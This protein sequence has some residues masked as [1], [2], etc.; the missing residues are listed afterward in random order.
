MKK[1]YKYQQTVD[2]NGLNYL[3]SQAE[4]PLEYKPGLDTWYQT[5]FCLWIKEG[6][7][8]NSKS[9]MDKQFIVQERTGHK[10]DFLTS[11]LLQSSGQM[12]WYER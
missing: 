1:V 2:I 6:K 3:F 8:R 4:I 5:I 10:K 12:L 7:I 9:R 11:L